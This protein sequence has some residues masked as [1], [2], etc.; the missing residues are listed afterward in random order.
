M[1]K[2]IKIINKFYYYYQIYV[3][4]SGYFKFILKKNVNFNYKII[5]DIIYLD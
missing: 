4:T 1:H 2:T 5:I 3:E